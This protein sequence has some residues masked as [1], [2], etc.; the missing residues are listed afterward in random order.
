MKKKVNLLIVATSDYRNFL[1]VLLLDVKKYFLKDCDVRVCIFTDV[2]Q[3]FPSA[4]RN[5]LYRIQHLPYPLPSL[6]RYQ[7]FY[8]NLNDMPQADY[9][10]YIDADI[11]IVSPVTSDILSARTGTLHR[12]YIG[13]EGT[14]ERRPDFT[15]AIP[16]GESSKYFVGSFWGFEREEFKIFLRTVTENTNTDLLSRRIPIWYDES[17]LNHYFHCNPPEK[18]LPPTYHAAE[19][20]E[21]KIIVSLN[22]DDIETFNV[23]YKP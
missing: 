19:D 18:E 1:P 13:S 20:D 10:F 22:K 12:G 16:E 14:P 21:K 5:Y 4:P 11:R 17:Y 2:F 15:C 23:K 7:Y 6:L 3:A 8:E 9:Y